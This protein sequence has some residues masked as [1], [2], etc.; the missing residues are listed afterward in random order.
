MYAYA[1][2]LYELASG[3]VPWTDE[4]PG[5]IVGMVVMDERPDMH[6]ECPATL[7]QLMQ[8]RWVPEPED[9]IAFIDVLNRLEEELR[10][11]LLSD[12][13]DDEEKQC[14]EEEAERTTR[15]C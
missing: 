7:W 13:D 8:E 4:A 14:R 1:C 2:V 6:P 12:G 10:S 5:D 3:E 9:R 15:G 11:V